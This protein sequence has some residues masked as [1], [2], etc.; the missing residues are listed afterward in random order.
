MTLIRPN[1]P[2]INRPDIEAEVRIA[3]MRYETALISNDIAV[4]DELFWSSSHAVRYGATE[5]LYGRDEIE[6]F[7]KSRP[8]KGLERSIRRLEIM[9]LGEDVA[10][11]NLE[12]QREG[13]PRVGR[14]SQTWI[15]FTK[16]WRIVSAHVSL[17]CR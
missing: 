7:R 3:V 14:Q 16:G 2:T 11:A 1:E 4:L 17:I 9:T 8:S 6:A 10:V 12:F 5:C 15:R 13:E